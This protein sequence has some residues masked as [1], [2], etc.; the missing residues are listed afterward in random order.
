MIFLSL[1]VNMNKVCWPPILFIDF[2]S[3]FESVFF[4]FFFFLFVV[5]FFFLF[6]CFFVVVF[7]PFL[8]PS[9][10]LLIYT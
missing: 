6:V 4:F 8:L 1:S 10:N 5:V 2:F 7:F 3:P 9:N